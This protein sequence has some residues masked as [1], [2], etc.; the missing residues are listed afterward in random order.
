[1]KWLVQEFLNNASN[2][3]RI[4]NALEKCSVEYLLVR[5]NKDS[6]LTVIDKEE[7]VP[8]NNSEQ[9]IK[10]FISNE[11]V[12]IY[13]SKAFAEI[14]KAM[15][16]KPGSFMTEQFEFEIQPTTN[17]RKIILTIQQKKMKHFHT[18]VI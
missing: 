10:S 3:I 7:K 5:V 11:H 14:A 16:L 1:M 2:V 6:S 12:M 9:V 13:G 8:L 17:Y 4:S 18:M 15:E